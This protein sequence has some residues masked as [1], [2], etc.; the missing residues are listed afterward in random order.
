MEVSVLIRDRGETTCFQIA[1]WMA[2]WKN[3]WVYIKKNM[4]KYKDEGIEKWGTWTTE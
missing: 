4:A 3:K 2:A 1:C